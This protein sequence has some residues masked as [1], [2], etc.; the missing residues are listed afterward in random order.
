MKFF[1]GQLLFSFSKPR[2]VIEDTEFHGKQLKRGEY[3]ISALACANM[4]ANKF[5]E[6]EKFDILRNPN[7]HL[8]FGSGVHICLGLKLAKAEAEI[9]FERLLTR[10]PR[11]RLVESNRKAE[12]VVWSKRL[13]LRS[14]KRL[15][16]EIS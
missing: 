1:G 15:N 6:P 14:I 5:V 7:P 9:A 13:G 8:T 16:L 3:I 2:F 12:P 11:L 10:F 4:D